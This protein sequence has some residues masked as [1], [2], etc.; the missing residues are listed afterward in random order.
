MAQYF[1]VHPETPQQRLINQ[2]VQIL[3]DG[4]VIAYPTDSSYALG[5][6][7]GDKAALDRIRE[8][9][10]L[11]NS[12]N[13]T[14]ACK[15]LKDIGTYAKM[16][17]YAY[18]LLKSHT[19]GPYTFILRATSEVPRRLQHPKRKTI[20]IR[21]PDHPASRALLNTLGEPLMSVTLQ[22]PGDDMPLNDPEAIQER[23]GKLI[24]AVVAGGPTGGGV[25]TVIDL[26]GEAAEVI[27]E[28]VGD[29]R[30]FQGA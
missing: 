11:D 25:S 17:N 29:T 20:G 4:G 26:T 10:R 13:F 5:C 30:V 21:V 14:M 12:H 19:P 28:G 3:A 24:D 18:R 1:E 2:A 7:L 16:E 22:M 27:R 15:D 8:I 23:I 6:R 9:R